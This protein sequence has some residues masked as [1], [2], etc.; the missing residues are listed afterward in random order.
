MLGHDNNNNRD[1]EEEELTALLFEE[2]ALQAQRY[3]GARRLTRSA[4]NGTLCHATIEAARRRHLAHYALLLDA[5][6]ARI[7]VL[8][9][10]LHAAAV[11]AFEAY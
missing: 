7:R 8:Q 10:R 2:H 3:W 11:A 6:A 1:R 5:A 9:G 4:A